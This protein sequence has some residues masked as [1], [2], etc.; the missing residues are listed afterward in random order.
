MLVFWCYFHVDCAV[1]SLQSYFELKGSWMCFVK[2][3]F[4]RYHTNLQLGRKMVVHEKID[5]QSIAWWISSI[6]K[7][8]E[9]KLNF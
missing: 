2:Q 8:I 7:N 1:G 4:S 9:S 5:S 3:I 6:E